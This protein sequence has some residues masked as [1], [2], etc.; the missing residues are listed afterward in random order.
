MSKGSLTGNWRDPSSLGH[1]AEIGGRPAWEHSQQAF[2]ALAL[3]SFSVFGRNH[4]RYVG[5][6]CYPSTQVCRFRVIP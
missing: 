1:S 3:L 6:V 4:V 5:S 2:A